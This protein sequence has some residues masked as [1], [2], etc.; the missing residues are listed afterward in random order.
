MKAMDLADY[1]IIKANELN[2]PV[3]NLKLQKVMYFLNAD[4]ML[5][6]NGKSLIEDEKFERWDY[7]PTIRSV[8]YEYSSYGSS[9]INIPFQHIKLESGEDNKLDIKLYNLDVTK[10]NQSVR[11]FIDENIGKLLK[12]KDP[13]ELVNECQKEPQWQKLSYNEEYSNTETLKY[14]KKHKFWEK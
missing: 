9:E 13:F 6:N 14:Y 5:N 7:G 2:K 12:F 11:N 4:Y 10:I 8:Y 3:Q 1:V